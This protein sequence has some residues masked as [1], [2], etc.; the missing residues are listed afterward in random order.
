MKI[1]TSQIPGYADMSA[2]DKLKALEGYEIKVPQLTPD[3]T[4]RLKAALSKA[5][6]EAA[7]YKRALRERQ[8]E[9]ERQEAERQEAD[10]KK[11]ELL[12]QYEA[13]RR[14]NAY[15]RQF[16]DAGYDLETATQMA[17]ALP[18][19]VSDEYFAA[20]KAFIEA[21]T[22]EIQSAALSHQP[23]LTSGAP[24]TSSQAD[25]DAQNKMRSYFGLPPI[26]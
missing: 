4:D 3:E 20:T 16:M 17:S 15:T 26:K 8:S 23:T 11:D 18:A 12:A 9:A 14:V 6:S 5:N 1:D 22:K 10:R 2:E 19:G 25:K 7:E 13:E 24:P 21:K